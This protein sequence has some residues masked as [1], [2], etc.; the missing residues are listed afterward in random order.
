MTEIESQKLVTMLT[1]AY[2]DFWRFLPADQQNLTAR[3]Y[4]HMMRDLDVEACNAAVGRLIAT[5][6]KMPTI[7][8]VRE[9]AYAQLEGRRIPGGEAWGRVQKAIA[10]E[11]VRR[12]PGV[13]FVFVDPVCA[14][15]VDAM[16]W[17][18]LCLSDDHTSDRARFIELYEQ[19]ARH[20]FEDGQVAQILPAPPRRYAV[21]GPRPIAALVSEV[22]SNSNPDNT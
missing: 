10:R 9:A 14:R 1:T 11:G 3:L 18:R 22:I 2:P 7:A 17:G 21:T 13:D 6:K 4:R 15:A 19:L 20:E 12:S 8:E 5:S 16:G